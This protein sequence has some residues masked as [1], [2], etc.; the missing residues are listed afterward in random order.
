M[1]RF[2]TIAFLFIGMALAFWALDLQGKLVLKERDLLTLRKE[3]DAAIAAAKA[4]RAEI[5]PPRLHDGADQAGP[6][7]NAALLGA[8]LKQID[9]PEMQAMLRTQSLAAARTEYGPLLQPWN[10]SAADSETVL[11]LLAEDYSAA[12][13]ERL[14]TLIGEARVKEL[15][16]FEQERGRDEA[17]GRY[18]EHLDI[19][20]F[21]LSEP[22]RAQLNAIFR[23]DGGGI[24]ANIEPKEEG[25]FSD[26]LIAKLRRKNEEQQSRILQKASGTLTPDQVNA[27]HSA[28]REQNEA[29]ETGM[30]AVRQLLNDGDKAKPIPT[31]PRRR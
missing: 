17:L 30:R 12:A 25:N 7:V 18:S 29:S 14:T 28:F 9:S 16:A 15:E 4:A 2:L 19:L 24:W 20:G 13:R 23:A 11:G 5:A 6:D 21:P 8:A 3:R 1:Y 27:L 31:A 10:L 22:Q 26:E